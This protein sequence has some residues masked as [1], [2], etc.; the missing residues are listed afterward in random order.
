MGPR[1][2]SG[3]IRI[4]LQDLG[5]A[6]VVAGWIPERR[7]NSVRLPGGRIV[8]ALWA[9]TAKHTSAI[10]QSVV[11]SSEAARSRRRVSRY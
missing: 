3:T 8:E 9:P 4:K 10:D 6:D 11:R 2:V 7:V 5:E 1:T